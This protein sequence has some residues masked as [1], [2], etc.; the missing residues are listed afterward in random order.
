MDE[1]TYVNSII[2]TEWVQGVTDCYWVIEDSFRV[3]DGIEL[4][5]PPW[6]KECKTG[7]AGKASLAS[8]IWEESEAV[9]GAVFAVYKD[10]V[11]CHVGR[12]LCGM[13]VHSDGSISKAG[14]CK[15]EKI[16]RMERFY[17]RVGM[18]VKYYTYK[19]A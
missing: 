8:G 4:P 15:A 10:G 13:A 19:G 12:I 11:M 16:R 14:H 17:N 2:G 6:R 1:A 5:T 7:E 3:L 18:T 9:D